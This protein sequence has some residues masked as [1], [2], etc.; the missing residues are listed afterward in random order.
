MG[1]MIELAK[2]AYD[3]YGESTGWTAHDDATM[4]DWD[5]LPAKQQAAW[6]AA[7]TAVRTK[8]DR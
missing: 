3:A 5:D 4:P 2:I 7:V 6:N 8:L 1:A